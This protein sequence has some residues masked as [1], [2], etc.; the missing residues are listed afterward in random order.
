VA[1]VNGYCSVADI[2]EHVNDSE[3]NSLNVSLIERAI[4]AASRAIDKYCGFPMRKFWKD[5]TP[6]TRVYAPNDWQTIWISDLA[7]TTGLVVGIGT[8]FTTI[9][10]ASDYQLGP[11]N[12]DQFGGPHAFTKISA[13]GSQLFPMDRTGRPTVRITGLHGW[14]A[15]PDEVTQACVIKSTS[16]LKRKDAVFGVAGFG[17]FGTAVRIRAEDPDVADLLGPFRRYGAGTTG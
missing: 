11:N 14:S 4:N 9:L 1:V 12:V 17:E 5:S 6:T 15:V 10:T 2:R 8:D 13:I 16:L 7:E 3:F